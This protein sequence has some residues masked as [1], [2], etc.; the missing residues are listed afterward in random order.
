M[1]APPISQTDAAADTADEREHDLTSGRAFPAYF[2]GRHRSV[3]MRA[4][5]RAEHG[6]DLEPAG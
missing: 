5:G 1:N 4:L 2:Q 6:I 3:Y